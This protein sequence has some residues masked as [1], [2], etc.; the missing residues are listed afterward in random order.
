MILK[1]LSPAYGGFAIAREDRV[2]FI[3]GA[4]PGEVV[5]TVVEEKKR[6]YLV[7]SV[8]QVV[9]PSEHRVEPECPVFGVCGGCQLQYVSYARQI[10]MKEEILHESLARLGG[11]EIGLSPS[12][13][14][15]QWHYRRR[16]QF[17][18]GKAGE[19]G[20]F[21][22]ASRDVVRIDACPLLSDGL[23]AVLSSLSS[24]PLR[25][26]GVSDIHVTCGDRAVAFVK[27]R[28][29]AAELG[30]QLLS[31]GLAGVIVE[32]RD[33][34]GE[35]VTEFDLN[36]IRYCVSAQSFIQAHWSLNC[37]VAEHLE[38]E[39][40]PLEG[41]AVLDLYAGAGNFS[42]PLARRGADVTAVEES[43]TAAEDGRQNVTLNSLRGCSFKAGTAE[44]FALK[45]RYDI[46]LLDPPRPGLTVEVR[47]KILEQPPETVVYLSCNPATLARD[48][49]QLKEK[50]DI[51]S[52][53]MIDFFPNTYHIEALALLRLRSLS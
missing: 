22:E 50:Y 46:I 31:L 28:S 11:I 52:V 20:F 16:A 13:I 14:G 21:R 18:V 25:L 34:S 3:R 17:K 48:L 43:P 33:A 36:G 49:K 30:A 12:L 7:T 45:K 40:L 32:G 51:M 1:A 10:S 2:I 4:I 38:T 27:G 47:R 37:R 24:S 35:T 6:D 9:E 29:P 44:R 8:T 15:D 39:L 5:D 41:K 53:M 26:Q 23:N 42:L 19:I